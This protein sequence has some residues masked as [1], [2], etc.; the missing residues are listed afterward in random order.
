MA[1][2][3]M[4]RGKDCPLKDRCYRHTAVENPHWQSWFTV[5]A[6]DHRTGVC[7]YFMER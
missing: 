6:Y 7:M 3:T 1:D 2:I 5:V 4:C